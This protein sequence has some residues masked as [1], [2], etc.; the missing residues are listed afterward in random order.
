VSTEVTTY[1][2]GEIRPSQLLFT[3]GIG[4]LIDLPHL[5]VIVMGLNMWNEKRCLPVREERLLNIV[6]AKLGPQVLHLL[7]PPLPE[8]ESY[9]PF[10]KSNFIGVPVSIF[11]KWMLCP[12]CRSL[13]P[14]SSGLLSFKGNNWSIAQ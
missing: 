2:V 10:D 8:E 1:K 4:S 9:V 7:S 5:S 13:I 11:P 12:Q 14:L 3:F 6:R